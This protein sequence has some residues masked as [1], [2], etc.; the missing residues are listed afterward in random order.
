MIG[1]ARELTTA[2]ESLVR[3]IFI[4]QL[5][6]FALARL[7]FYGNLLLVEQVDA[8][9]NDAKGALANLLADVVVDADD[10]RGGA[11]IRH[12]E[13]GGMLW[14]QQLEVEVDDT[15]K[16]QRSD[17]WRSKSVSSCRLGP[18]KP[19]SCLPGRLEDVFQPT[20]E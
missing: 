2:Y 10:V 12:S 4:V 9:E 8:L 15:G 17:R 7:E 13:R 3:A 19:A 20:S 1:V 18:Y 16:P 14:V 5:R 6:S 11:V